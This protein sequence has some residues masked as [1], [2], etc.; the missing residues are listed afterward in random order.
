MLQGAAPSDIALLGRI[1]QGDV[2]AFQTFYGR[3]ASRVLAYARQ[4]CRGRDV[5][6]D[7]M[8]EVFVA[9]WRRAASFRPDRGDPAGW[10]Y[11]I[12]RNKLVD[13]WRR[14][15]ETAELNEMDDRRLASA[16]HLG[17]SGDLRLSVRQALSQVA[18]EQRRAIEMAYFGGLTYEETAKRLQL[19]VGTLKSRI[20]SGLK[21]LRT[22]LESR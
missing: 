4:L 10:L 2:D 22:L 11:T 7:V 5:S 21:T 6:E 17:D 20:R 3:Y 8:Q 9:V 19:P 12:T 18:P 14:L 1:A 16:E 15:G 13:H